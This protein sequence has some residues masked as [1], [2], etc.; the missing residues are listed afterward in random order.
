M[1][2]LK[3]PKVIAALVVALL[4]GIVFL[5]N[6]QPAVSLRFFI[7]HTDPMPLAMALLF[8]FLLGLVTGFLAFS[9]WKSQRERAKQSGPAPAP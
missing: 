6:R 2:R 9:R 4:A 7:V 3:N 1:E 8:T 5:Q